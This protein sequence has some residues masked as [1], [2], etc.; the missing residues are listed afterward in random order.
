M[1]NS[2]HISIFDI[3][4]I[5][6]LI[7]DNLH[8][9]QHLHPCLQVSRA[10]YH[11]FQPQVLRHVEFIN[12]KKHQTWAILDSAARIISLTVDISDAGWFL[13]NSNDGNKS[14]TSSPCINLQE[15]HCVD[16][17]YQPKRPNVDYLSAATSSSSSSLPR[18]SYVDQTKNALLMIKNNPRLHTLIVQYDDCEYKTD[19]FSE[20]VFKSLAAHKSLAKIHIHLPIITSSSWHKIICS[21]PAGLRDF[22]LWCKE[23]YFGWED[24]ENEEIGFSGALVFPFLERLCLKD[25]RS[26]VTSHWEDAF[27][28]SPYTPERQT[29][30]PAWNIKSEVAAFVRNSPRLRDLVLRTYNGKV[31]RL[32]DLLVVSCPELETIDLAVEYVEEDYGDSDGDGIDIV[33]NADDAD[34]AGIE[35]T[36]ISMTGSYFTKLKEFRI[37]G[38]WPDSTQRA[39]ARLVSRSV[40]TLEIVWFDRGQYYALVETANPFHIDAETSW[41]CCTQLKE[42]V[43]CQVG[44]LQMSDYCWDAPYGHHSRCTSSSTSTVSGILTERKEDYSA[45]F[46]RLEKLRLSVKE[47]LWEDCPNEYLTDSDWDEPQGNVTPRTVEDDIRDRQLKVERRTK[48]QEH[49]IAFVLQVRE[50]FGRLKDLKR[51]SALEIG[52]CACSRIQG[53]TLEQVLQ[54]FYETEFD[55]DDD[56]GINHKRRECD[57]R[58][59]K[60]WWGPVTKADLSWLGLSWPTEA[61]QQAQ[62]DITQLAL[63]SSMRYV[64][65]DHT[66]TRHACTGYSRIPE[67][68]SRRV[69]R[70]WQDWMHL[71]GACPEYWSNR[72][73]QWSSR[74]YRQ[75]RGCCIQDALDGAVYD[76]YDTLD[77]DHVVFS[78]QFE[79]FSLGMQVE[80]GARWK[81]RKANRGRL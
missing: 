1:Y 80:T 81:S 24:E 14:L 49:R 21:L 75:P 40:D 50:I 36:T 25:N 60:G 57:N 33:G 74:G 27:F 51:L 31:G 42:L 23:G 17:D 13:N 20:A 76:G 11:L 34:G 8:S 28:P 4:H 62:A 68:F 30:G 46:N 53:M 63:I 67:P 66:S 19:H 37:E 61:E 32:M 16:Y 78:R 77:G 69:G 26:R 43:L 72:N 79:K 41:T 73:W 65:C 18:S 6:D 59:Q 35:T 44:G 39:V 54:M 7:C 12:L 56:K 3:P 15:L 70:V 55:E 45:A 2:H 29:Y 58:T 10:W 52:W 47:P 64:S 48:N 9:K 71:T 38:E 5:L 22:E